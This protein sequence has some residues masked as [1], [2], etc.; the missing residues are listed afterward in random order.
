M[1]YRIDYVTSAQDGISEQNTI[2]HPRPLTLRGLKLV[3]KGLDKLLHSKNLERISGQW[4][5]ER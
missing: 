3:L 4:K 5:L 1:K 2:Y